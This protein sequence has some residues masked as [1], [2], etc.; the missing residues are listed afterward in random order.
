MATRNGGGV[1]VKWKGNP[2][3]IKAFVVL[4]LQK[5]ILEGYK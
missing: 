2:C 4:T 1:T 5:T 3:D